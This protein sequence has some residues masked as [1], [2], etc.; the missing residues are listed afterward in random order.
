MRYPAELLNDIPGNASMAGQRLRL[1]QGFI[2]MI[3]QKAHPPNGHVSGARFI[4]RSMKSRQRTFYAPFRREEKVSILVLHVIRVS[5]ATTN[6]F[7]R[8]L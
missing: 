4:I 7:F 2:V 8:I 3:L 6:F 5:L 1:K